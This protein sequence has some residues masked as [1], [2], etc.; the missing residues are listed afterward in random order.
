M[1]QNIATIIAAI[2]AALSS[3]TAAWIGMN[4]AGS[5]YTKNI[6]SLQEIYCAELQ[7]AKE[8]E[9]QNQNESLNKLN[10]IIGE[11]IDVIYRAFKARGYFIISFL[12]L[13]ECTIVVI[14]GLSPIVSEINTFIFDI[15]LAGFCLILGIVLLIIGIQIRFGKSK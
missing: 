7:R 10:F 9:P 12:L 4:S 13:I 6:H 1:D 2:I 8:D 14:I 15:V 3:I 5:A 11:S